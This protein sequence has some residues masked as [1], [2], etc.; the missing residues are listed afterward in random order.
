MEPSK[1]YNFSVGMRIR[2]VRDSLNLS[3]EAFSEKCD[4]SS[5]FLSAVESGKKAIT[6]KTLY[7][8][9]TATGVSADYLILGKKENVEVDMTLEMM[10]SLDPNSRAYAFQ[11][12]R[13]YT[14]AVKTSKISDD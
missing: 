13:N 7:K 9:C 5:S 6:S 3:R 8:I 4:I 12:M 2:E 11:I 1:D 14:A 10:K